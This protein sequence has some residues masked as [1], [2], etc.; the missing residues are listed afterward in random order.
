MSPS[1]ALDRL[2]S[3]ELFAEDYPA[4]GSSPEAG[5]LAIRRS[6]CGP[7]V[8]WVRVLGHAKYIPAVPLL[9][10]LWNACALVPVRNAAGHALRKIGTRP[11]RAALEALIEEPESV[12]LAVHAIFDADPPRAF[13]RCVHHFEPG[14]LQLDRG[15]TTATAILA[16]FCPSMFRFVGGVL[17]PEWTEPRAPEWFLADRRWMKLCI[18]LRHHE[19]LGPTAKD[20]LRSNDQNVVRPALEEAVATQPPRAITAT[21]NGPGDLLTRYQ[22]GAH[23]AVWR[24]LRAYEAIDGA[25]RAEALAVAQATMVRVAR[26]ADQLAERL[27]Q[28][29]WTVIGGALRTAFEPPDLDAIEGIEQRTGSL[30]P[31]LRAFW[32]VVGSVEFVWDH[33]RSEEPPSLGVGV[34]MDT[35]D[36]LSI[37]PARWSSDRFEDWDELNHDVHPELWRPYELDLAPDVLCKTNISGGPPYGVELPFRGADPILQNEAHHLPFV[38]YLRLCM[39]WAGFPGLEA[40][41]DRE[42]VRAFVETMSKGL[43]PF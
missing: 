31:S 32:E 40:H 30:P 38:D 1:E 29:E 37:G 36:P 16:T 8:E 22:R 11:A 42:D 33:D 19:L 25:L 13:D 43:E 12:Q 10:E 24:E 5:I 27:A 21:S 35:M 28:Q 17:V 20:V 9:V 39:R 3:S 26:A 4:R 14:A 41:A 15:V 34:P 6:D 23:E 7:L 2:R 18:Q